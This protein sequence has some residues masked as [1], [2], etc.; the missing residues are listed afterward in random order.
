[1]KR[2][3][4]GKDPIGKRIHKADTA[5]STIVGVVSDIRNFGPVEEPTAGGVSRVS[6]VGQGSSNFALMVRAKRGE[7]SRPHRGRFA[8]RFD[9]WI[10]R[11]RSRMSGQCRR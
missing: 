11:W 5:F 9:R 6:S 2:D 4:Q 7:S 1:M 10:S 3:F 8:R